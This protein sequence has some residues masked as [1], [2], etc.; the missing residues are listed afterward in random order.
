MTPDA[1]ILLYD[2]GCGFCSDVVKF[3]LR[4]DRIGTLRFASLTG[5]A[6]ARILAA[7]PKLAGIDSAVWI[8]PRARRVYTHSATWLRVARYLGGWWRILE[9][10][11][12]IPGPLR[13]LAYRLVA[14]HRH[15]LGLPIGED[16][17]PQL[18]MRK[19]FIDY[20]GEQSDERI[21]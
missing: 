6:G 7:Y 3:I 1:P 12:I 18:E 2:G 19:R 9:L 16:F 21:R 14:K 11:W 8:D 5:D 17:L 20:D 10:A 4:R 13:D 15:A